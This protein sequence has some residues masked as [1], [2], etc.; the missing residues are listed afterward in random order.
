MTWEMTE[1]GSVCC[2]VCNRDA[3]EI[4]WAVTLVQAWPSCRV[5]DYSGKEQ[6]AGSGLWGLVPVDGKS[7]QMC[8]CLGCLLCLA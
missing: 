7:Q 5:Q 3:S 8:M 2:L 4:R 6:A 1:R